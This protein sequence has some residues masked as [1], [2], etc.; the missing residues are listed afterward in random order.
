MCAAGG[1]K[2]GNLTFDETL[3]EG[4]LPKSSSISCATIFSKYI[5]DM[6]KNSTDDFVDISVLTAR[7]VNPLTDQQEKFIGLG[8]LSCEDGKNHREPLNLVIILDISGSMSGKKLELAKSCL[9]GIF[10]KLNEDERIGILTFND[11]CGVICDIASK[12]DINKEE[13]F[14][15]IRLISANGGTILSAGYDPAVAMLKSQIEKDSQAPAKD[16]SLPKNNRIIFL[17][18]AMIDDI[19]EKDYLYK[20]NVESSQKPWNIFTSFIGVGMDF[21]SDLIT[22]L[23]KVRGSNY[24]S[25]IRDEDFKKTLNDDFN[26]IVTPLCF[27][28][29]VSMQ[30]SKYE[31]ERTYGSEYDFKGKDEDKGD[32]VNE[33]K[34]GGVLKIDTLSAYEKTPGGI[35]GGV[36][37]IKLKEKIEENKEMDDK[38]LISITYEDISGLKHEVKKEVVVSFEKDQ[39]ECFESVGIRKAYL[40]G[41]Y[42]CFIKEYIDGKYKDHGKK[43]EIIEK[44]IGFFEKEM[45]ILNDKLLLNEHENLLLVVHKKNE[46]GAPLKKK[47]KIVLYFE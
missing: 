37:L 24:F 17:T 3:K 42:T 26:Y 13:L 4:L 6:K 33:M 36:V 7:A 8:L 19:S 15:K 31:I 29:Y 5:F 38:I 20:I 25:V 11:E 46:K 47:R 22:R 35:K 18:D 41:Q 32:E 43:E 16:L 10:C 30:S 40:L 45:K 12:K 34:K 27:D 39:K 2:G 21:D 23:T 9:E 1:I 44:F 14:K 28:V